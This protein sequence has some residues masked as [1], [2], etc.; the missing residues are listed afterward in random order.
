MYSTTLAVLYQMRVTKTNHQHFVHLFHHKNNAWNEYRGAAT[1]SSIQYSHTGEQKQRFMPF[2]DFPVYLHRLSP[3][4]N[5]C[6]CLTSLHSA[7]VTKIHI[8]RCFAVIVLHCCK[9]P[10]GAN[11]FFCG[12]SFKGTKLCSNMNGFSRHNDKNAHFF[13][14][15]TIRTKH[16]CWHGYVFQKPHHFTARPVRIC[17]ATSTLRE[18][19]FLTFFAGSGHQLMNSDCIT[20]AL[21][22]V[23]SK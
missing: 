18:K 17:S 15:K 13:Q 22:T 6:L 1:C 20:F 7:D 4:R 16:F 2:P 21:C 10:S 23:L 19:H 5:I 8:A 11:C 9:D 12:N 3:N 14:Y